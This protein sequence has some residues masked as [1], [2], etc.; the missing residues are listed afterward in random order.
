MQW[1]NSQKVWIVNGMIDKA[2]ANFLGGLN[3]DKIGDT[4]ISIGT[5]PLREDDILKMKD[6]GITGVLNLQ[7]EYDIRQRGVPWKNLKAIYQQNNIRCYRFPLDDNNEDEYCASL[8]V[9]AQ[10]LN[11]M[12]NNLG[13]NVYV[14]CSSGICRAPAV[15]LVYLCLFKRV[16][17]WQNPYYVAQFVK[18]FHVNSCPNMRAVQRVVEANLEFQRQQVDINNKSHI[19]GE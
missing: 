9:V 16:K 18:A 8:F 12:I 1:K 3:F 15:A 7:T 10:H 4:H 11:N 14:H 19:S 13:L 6:K 17:Q 2:D 5:Y